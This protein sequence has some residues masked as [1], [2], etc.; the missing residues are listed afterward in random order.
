[1]HIPSLASLSLTGLLAQA[2]EE[3]Q[4]PVI[5]L[6]GTALLQLAIFLVMYFVLRRFLFQPYLQMR[7]ERARR[8]EGAEAS[9]AQLTQKRQTLDADYQRRL[10]AAR[11]KAE[12]ERVKLAGEARTREADLLADARA[13][14]QARIADTR[15]TIDAQV[16]QAQ[17]ALDQQIAPLAQQ[18]ASKLLGREV[19]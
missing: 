9:A 2:A 6:D 16:A 18:L 11:A 15:K 10:D 4:P 1:M 8:I 5:D 19:A 13:R 14:A 3:K 7:D 12:E 17:V